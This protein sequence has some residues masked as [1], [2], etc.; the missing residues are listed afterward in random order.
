MINTYVKG[1]DD[2]KLS[3]HFTN[4]EFDC[5]CKNKG[6]AITYVDT[7]LIELLEQLRAKWNHP[8]R[9]ISGFRCVAHNAKQGGKAGSQ[10]LI[11]KACD[12]DISEMKKTVGLNTLIQDCQVFGGLGVSVKDN[13][14][15]VDVRKGHARWTY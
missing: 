9:I 13:F 3:E 1:Q 5:H 4:L 14:I 8:I 15:H 12:F 10:H 7:D 11:G 6:C 2:T